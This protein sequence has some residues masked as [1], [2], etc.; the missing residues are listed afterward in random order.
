MGD[1]NILVVD[2]ESLV[3]MELSNT[4]MSL[5]YNVIDYATNSKMTKSFLN[6]FPSIN[7]IMMD[8]NLNEEIDGIDLYKSIS[9]EA[10][11]IYVTAYKDDTNISRAIETDPLGYLVKPYDE[12]EL[13]ALLKLASYKLS[14]KSIK[15]DPR[16]SLTEIGDG[17]YFDKNKDQLTYKQLPI[18]LTK[19]ELQLL[20]LL[21]LSKDNKVSYETIENEIY[22]SEPVSSSAI[23]T[24]IYRLRCKLEHKFIE[25]EFSYGIKLK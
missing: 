4:V 24:L 14:K 8:I 25:N 18:K 12:A 11:V 20:K 6:K 2:D 19:K 22:D 7:L 16:T 5:G 10:A 3:A 13:S 23:R 9:S 21:L 15:I 17:Y 1:L